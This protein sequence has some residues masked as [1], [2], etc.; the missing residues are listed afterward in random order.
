V[1]KLFPNKQ[2]T[3]Q[4]FS[5]ILIGEGNYNE[6]WIQFSFIFDRVETAHPLI[7]WLEMIPIKPAKNCSEKYRKAYLCKGCDLNNP[8]VRM[9]ERI[10]FELP[11]EEHEIRVIDVVSH[12]SCG[13]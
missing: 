12:V 9:T 7:I 5:G 11:I 3:K 4:D 6:N 8:D 13:N 1:T 2:Y 10:F